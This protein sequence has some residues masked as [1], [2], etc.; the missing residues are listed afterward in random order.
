MGVTGTRVLYVD[1]A[2]FSGGAQRS[3]MAM[4]HALRDVGME[5]F[6]AGAD[7]SVGGL[8]ESCQSLGVPHCALRSRHWSRSPLGLWEFLVDRRRIGRRLR[9]VAG[10]WRP[11]I[12]HAN[13]VRAALLVPK[14]LALQSPLV[15]HDRDLRAPGLARRLVAAKA[16]CIVAISEAVAAHWPAGCQIVP[17]GLAVADIARALPAAEYTGQVAM[18][19]DFVPWKRHD[20]FLQAFA[21]VR[22]HYPGGKAVLVGRVRDGDARWLERTRAL[23]LELGLGESVT[24]LT[25]ATCAWP[26]LAACRALVSCALDEPFGRTVVEALA[27]GKPVVAVRGAGPEEILANTRA[28][29][30]VEARPSAI[31]G[32]LLQAWDW[33]EDPER[34]RAARR[35][36]DQFSIPHMRR[37][38]CEVYGTLQEAPA[39]S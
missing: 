10:E 22:K 23:A 4:V 36:A 8:L 11:T 9:Q 21:D 38:I 17:N 24:F 2:P 31:A 12:I 14:G 39:G 5:R 29:V 1:C 3:L 20:L 16:S 33:A 30:L 27:L 32:G 15:V 25:E 18:V 13:T 28:G 19:A 26:Q 37:R 6:V 35:C 34:A 7:G